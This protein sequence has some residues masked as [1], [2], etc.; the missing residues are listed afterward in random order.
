MLGCG[1]LA[2]ASDDRRL[3]AELATIENPLVDLNPLEARARLA[4]PSHF[5]SNVLD[6]AAGED[7]LD[8]AHLRG[9]L[10]FLNDFAYDWNWRK[11]PRV[12]AR[13]S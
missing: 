7:L 8:H 12:A 2:T 9:R 11:C 5:V 13:L 3:L 6:S 4:L 1:S 10:L